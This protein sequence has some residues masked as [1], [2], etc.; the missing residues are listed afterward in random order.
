[1]S[2][3]NINQVRNWKKT[4]IACSSLLSYP[5]DVLPTCEHITPSNLYIEIRNTKN[6]TRVILMQGLDKFKTPECYYI[7][8]DELNGTKVICV[9]CKN[10]YC[11]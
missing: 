3:E 10:F 2:I 5:P 1:M 6:I 4:T 7:N 11:Q 8:C 9:V